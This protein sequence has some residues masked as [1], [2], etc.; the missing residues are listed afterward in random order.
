[1]YMTQ[2]VCVEATLDRQG[3]PQLRL[4]CRATDEGLIP[5]TIV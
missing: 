5:E 4:F 2:L 1:M 3:N